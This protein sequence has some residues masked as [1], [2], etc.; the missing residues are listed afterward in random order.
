MKICFVIT[1]LGGGGAER[2]V[3]LLSEYFVLA[4]HDVTVICTSFNG[5]RSY[6]VNDAID[7]ITLVNKKENF[8]N[9]AK[10]LRKI[11]F[12]RKP[13]FVISFLPNSNF[14]VN[15][16]KG[17]KV[18]KIISSERNS[19]LDSPHS[20][21]LRLLRWYT[22]NR[23]DSIVFHSEGAKQYFSKGI[24][25]KGIVIPNP[26]L[27]DKLP[28]SCPKKK[29]FIAVGRITPQKNYSL[30]LNAFK[31]F[32]SYYP[33]Y[34]LSIYGRDFTNGYIDKLIFN[35]KLNHMENYLLSFLHQK[36]KFQHL[37]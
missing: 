34:K 14:L 20:R 19:P 9:K 25:Q 31:H 30:L 28:V 7:V 5:S 2:V 33:E 37:I 36:L 6:K 11:F 12:D 18:S 15:L 17:Y 32:H 16:S 3:S 24:Q 35:L 4:G 29:R 22:F 23:A 1:Q 13:D 27:F 10:K 8:I 21:V 26:I